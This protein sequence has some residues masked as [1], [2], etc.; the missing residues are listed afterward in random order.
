MYI[1]R[2]CKAFDKLSRLQYTSH[3]YANYIFY[4][5]GMY[6]CT[7]KICDVEQVFF[8]RRNF[9]WAL[10]VVGNPDNVMVICMVIKCKLYT[11]G[12]DL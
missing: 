5:S 2:R 7:R 1:G 8:L 3:S 4:K 6:R 9:M 11:G 10:V 12:C